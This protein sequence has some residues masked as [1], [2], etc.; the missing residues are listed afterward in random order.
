MKKVILFFFGIIFTLAVVKV[1]AYADDNV[2]AEVLKFGSAG[3]T[4]A[5]YD[6]S[7]TLETIISTINADSDDVSWE[8]TLF[9]SYVVTET[10]T[11]SKDI[12]IDLN[13]NNI[14][15]DGT[16]L[17]GDPIF[18]VGGVGQTANFELTDGRATT[19]GYVGSSSSNATNK[20]RGIY[21][22]PGSSFILRDAIIDNC[23]AGDGNFGGGV[24]VNGGSFSFDGGTISNCNAKEG[25]GVYVASRGNS[26][27]DF[28][29]KRG[30]IDSCSALE[31][32]GGVYMAAGTKFRLGA[33]A[34]IKNCKA[35]A[36]QGYSMPEDKVPSGGGIFSKASVI[37]CAN[38]PK[39]KGCEATDGAGIYIM[40]SESDDESKIIVVNISDCNA[41]RYGGGIYV[42]GTTLNLQGTGISGCSATHGGGIYA[43]S[44]SV[45]NIQDDIGYTGNPNNANATITGNSASVN[46]GGIYAAGEINVRDKTQITGNTKNGNVNNLYLPS[47]VMV[48]VDGDLLN[49]ATI[50][51]SQEQF[52]EDIDALCNSPCQFGLY[53]A[54]VVSSFNETMAGMFF[55]DAYTR[56]VGN[57]SEPGKIS[58]RLKNDAQSGAGEPKNTSRVIE[59]IDYALSTNKI[60][61]VFNVES[62]TYE[63]MKYLQDNPTVTLILNYVYEGREYKVVI[64]GKSAEAD[65][66]IPCYGPLY[67]YGRYGAISR[68]AVSINVPSENMYLIK[69]GDTL[70]KIALKFGTNVDDLLAL[71]PYIKNRNLIYAGRTLRIR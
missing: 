46:G 66:K 69:S 16:M 1:N 10:I 61:E 2:K 6:E 65:I 52:G 50:G 70:K 55:Y 47:G 15:R 71:N 38:G 40:P 62:L 39:I 57:I 12:T 14:V 20:G 64:P 4:L 21:V 30:E 32:G 60:A 44:A 35:E 8:I 11:I 3:D 48:N 9:D 36:P 67:L 56:M 31:S 45:L 25:G 58:W 7:T 41:G 18:S 49:G 42:V 37:E 24:Y 22:N 23:S 27:L 54:T 5:E 19:M 17:A 26:D 29:F 68:K 28:I 33:G 13:G 53:D 63:E 34:I 59:A 51:I 43:D